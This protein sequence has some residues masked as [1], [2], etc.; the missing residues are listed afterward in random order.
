MWFAGNATSLGRCRLL[1]TLESFLLSSYP[2]E[3]LQHF[4]ATPDEQ[5]NRLIAHHLEYQQQL[6]Q[7][8]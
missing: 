3:I 1:T 8:K 6:Q 4:L 7:Q 2:C 5:T